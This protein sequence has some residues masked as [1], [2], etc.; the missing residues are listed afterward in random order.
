M[1]KFTAC[2]TALLLMGC[3]SAEA[4]PWNSEPQPLL[5]GRA[6][7][8]ADAGSP[9]AWDRSARV[10]WFL[11]LGE[12][13]A[14]RWTGKTFQPLKY[15]G[16][17]PKGNAGLLVDEG[18]HALYFLDSAGHPRQA[19]VARDGSG[20]THIAIGSE[21]LARLLAVDNRSHSV[22]GYD[23]VARGIRQYNYDVKLKAWASSIIA[24]GLGEAGDAAAWD[25][26]FHVLYSSH[27]TADATVAR[28]SHARSL[29]N[30]TGTDALK[31]WPLVAT[32]W[33][34]GKWSS[35]VLDE[36]GVPQLPAVRATD[37]TVF[38]A[39]RDELTKLR[40]FR[41]VG[42]GKMEILGSVSGWSGADTY[43]DHDR[44]KIKIPTYPGDWGN[45]DSQTG[46]ASLIATYV[47]FG[48]I[49]LKGPITVVPYYEPVWTDTSM[50]ARLAHFRALVN[51]KQNRLVQH[52]EIYEGEIFREQTGKRIVGYLYRDAS[53]VLARRGS[54]A[55]LFFVFPGATEQVR[56]Y[57]TLDDTF[58]PANPPPDF[59]SLADP[60]ASFYVLS[61]D[62][63]AG[64]TTDANTPF[65]AAHLRLPTAV[66]SRTFGHRYDTLSINQPGGR[67]RDYHNYG[68]SF[69][70]L[71]SIA[72]DAPSGVTFYTQAPDP[73]D[74]EDILSPTYDF[75]TTPPFPAFR[76]PSDFKS[77]PAWWPRVWIVMVY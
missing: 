28:H 77:W 52:R 48:S 3:I 18:W 8:R 69:A 25:S 16:I 38:Y 36:T 39:R 71:S 53:G 40:T 61:T 1:S 51:L 76:A 20:L 50:P 43:E 60:N 56:S 70:A 4:W 67:Y 62:I 64:A 13:S 35:R 22:F 33:D 31:P 12:L 24:S 34:G 10:L 63:V 57:A 21:S 9:L 75:F 15:A 55:E 14:A 49:R 26:A 41:P 73:S 2:A 6:A 54:S 68:T 65:I 45:S 47:G 23:A 27:Q 32:A 59:A 58:D 46:N 30:S 42:D 19:L 74:S 5:N 37:H 11:N 17:S 66:H 29:S 7:I 44:Y 72:G